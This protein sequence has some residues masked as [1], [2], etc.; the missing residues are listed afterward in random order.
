MEYIY[1]LKCHEN[2]FRYVLRIEEK[3]AKDCYD[4]T[5]SNQ[6]SMLKLFAFCTQFVYLLREGLKTFNTP[7]YRQFAKRLG[8]I[9]R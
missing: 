2:L 3:D 4:I 6:N 8:S 9:I 1:V 5:K 7:K